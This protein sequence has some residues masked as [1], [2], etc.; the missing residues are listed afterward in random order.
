[1]TD[2]RERPLSAVAPGRWLLFALGW[3]CV[4]L[5]IIGICTPMMPGTVFLIIAA[6]VFFFVVR[7]LNALM[8]R[9][10]PEPPV[11]RVV[12]PCPEC[13]SDIPEDAR[14]CAFCTAEVGAV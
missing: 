12:R 9:L 2:T 10:K 5:C 7:P 13:L 14:R 11:D 4:G 8:A 3:V 1:M 6:V